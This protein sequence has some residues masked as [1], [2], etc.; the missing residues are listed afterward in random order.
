MHEC[1]VC[2]QACDCDG[3]DLWTDRYVA[4]GCSC[5]CEDE[6]DDGCDLAPNGEAGT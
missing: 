5:P 6:R 1:P 3:D 4:G 2:Y